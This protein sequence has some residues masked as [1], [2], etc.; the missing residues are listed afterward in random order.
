MHLRPPFFIHHFATIGSTNDQLKSMAEAPEF[1][2]IVADEQTAGR[3][4]RDRAWHS[5]PGEGLYLS[6]LLRP[7]ATAAAGLPLV[8]LLSAVAV[9]EAMRESGVAGVD[10][11]WPN[12]VLVNG[13]KAAG[14]LVE[15]ASGGDRLRLIVGIGVNLN[16]AAFPP[17]L[18]ATA[19]SLRIETGREIDA[20][21]FRDRLLDRLAEGYGCWA[22]GEYARILDCWRELSSSAR[23]ARVRVSLDDEEILGV[24]D[25]VAETGALRVR[26]DAG[27]VRTILAGDVVRLRATHE[28]AKTSR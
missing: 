22:R 4:R 11:K 25:G 6:V 9:A 8:S 1:T 20:A 26:T 24:T 15:G 21:A 28:D 16:H 5:A 17:A 2:C 19:T 13:R 10:I 12:D 7:A 3:G 23:G 14:I 18:A 27:D